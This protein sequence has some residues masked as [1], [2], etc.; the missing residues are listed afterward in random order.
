MTASE[1]LLLGLFV[2]LLIGV[3]ITWQLTKIL[4]FELWML[5]AGPA[6][7]AVLVPSV[8]YQTRP[9]SGR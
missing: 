5:A 9:N 8:W 1:R 6:A 4:G 2:V 7:G 3:A